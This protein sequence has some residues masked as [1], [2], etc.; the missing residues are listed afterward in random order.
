M[1][2]LHLVACA[3]ADGIARL[4]KVFGKP[5]IDGRRVPDFAKRGRGTTAADKTKEAKLHLIR[6]VLKSPTKINLNDD[7]LIESQFEQ[8]RA[9][10][11]TAFNKH[12]AYHASGASYAKLTSLIRENLKLEDLLL[13]FPGGG[14]PNVLLSDNVSVLQDLGEI[15]DAVQAQAVKQTPGTP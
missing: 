13:I 2:I 9:I 4:D 5:V 11:T 14:S 1:N 3:L 12:D 6:F 15:F 10:I 8:V 7:K